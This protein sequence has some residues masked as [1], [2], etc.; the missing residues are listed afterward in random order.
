ME[1]IITEFEK[2][3][4]DNTIGYGESSF[5]FNIDGEKKE[6]KNYFLFSYNKKIDSLD[7]ISLNIQSII[8][9]NNF[10]DIL[11]KENKNEILKEELDEAINY[12]VEAYVYNYQFSKDNN[13]QLDYLNG[14]YSKN[15]YEY[16]NELKESKY[17]ECDIDVVKEKAL[18]EKYNIIDEIFKLLKYFI[19]K[20]IPNT[21]EGEFA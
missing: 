17:N 7:V 18:F 3:I 21:L 9:I 6:E 16:F 12:L 5:C 8:S 13:I 2:D 20:I 11:S 15:L 1:E 19:D 4:I 14:I 10:R